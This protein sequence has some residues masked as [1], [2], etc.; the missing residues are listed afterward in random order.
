MR[1]TWSIPQT[2]V[3]QCR[4][5]ELSVFAEF[6]WVFIWLTLHQGT[7]RPV[8]PWNAWQIFRHMGYPKILW[9]DH[10]FPYTF[11][12]IGNECPFPRALE[13]T[14]FRMIIADASK[15]Q[16]VT[17]LLLPISRITSAFIHTGSDI[18]TSTKQH[19]NRVQH[20]QTCSNQQLTMKSRV[21][22]SYKISMISIFRTIF[23]NVFPC[24]PPSTTAGKAGP[25]TERGTER[26]RNGNG[27]KRAHAK[28]LFN[29]CGIRGFHL[30]F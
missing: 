15:H 7:G 2:Y 14:F 25:N 13:R 29:I 16:N 1:C 19:E 23:S 3:F 24:F 12:V 8:K 20:A 4:E 27:M 30:H 21:S 17:R 22:A 10:Q 18:G 5:S 9:Q 26:E 11:S 6:F 28:C